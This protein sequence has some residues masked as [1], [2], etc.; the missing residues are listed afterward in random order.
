MADGPEQREAERAEQ[1]ERDI[2][3]LDIALMLADQE[4]GDIE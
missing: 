4:R 3:D 1:Y 2:D